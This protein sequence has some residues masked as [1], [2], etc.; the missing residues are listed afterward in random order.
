MALQRIPGVNTHWLHGPPPITATATPTAVVLDAAAERLTMVGRFCHESGGGRVVDGVEFLFGTVTKTNGSTFQVSL[1]H[2]DPVSGPV[3]REDGT[4]DQTLTIPNA[5]AGFVTNAWYGGDFDGAATRTLAIGELVAVVFQFAAF[6]A[7]DSAALRGAGVLANGVIDNQN[8]VV[9]NV[10]GTYAV[11]S[12]LANVI[13]RC[14]DGTFG[15]L[16]EALPFK[17]LNAHVVNVGT[18]GADEY[19]LGVHLPFPFESDMLWVEAL[20]PS[21]ADSEALVYSGGTAM[22]TVVLDPNTLRLSS[23]THLRVPYAPVVHAAGAL[24]RLALRPTSVNSLTLY[25][26]D[27]NEAGHLSCLP[28]GTAFHT[29]TRVDQG[30]TWTPL[31]TNRLLAGIRLAAF[32]DSPVDALYSQAQLDAAVAAVQPPQHHT[33]GGCSSP[34][35]L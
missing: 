14:T 32:N 35:G 11:Q 9:A 21:T 2:V 33:L 1:Q 24:Y 16:E 13:F 19:A 18:V 30:A 27:V 22:T 23:A 12:L 34:L 15:T 8:C 7:G 31:V 26:L 28:G 29:W 4:P 25:S 3:V 17:A 10:T 6:V 20:L 5:A